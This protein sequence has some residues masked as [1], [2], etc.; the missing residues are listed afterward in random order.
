MKN[1]FI[2]LMLLSTEI[3]ASGKLLITPSYFTEHSKLLP[4]AGIGIYEHLGLGLY[5]DSYNGVGVS[6][7][8]DASD[9]AWLVSRH[10]I[11]T[12]FGDL[13]V[14]IGMALKVSEQGLVGDENESNIHVKIGYKLW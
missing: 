11:G 7:R 2:A 8:Y 6:P 13:D 14:S 5:Y 1:L 4:A 10:D 9:V 12:Y 3:F